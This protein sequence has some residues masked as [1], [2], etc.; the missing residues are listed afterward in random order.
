MSNSLRFVADETG[1]GQVLV[2]L[3]GKILARMPYQAAQQSA[4]ALKL[5]ASIAENNANPEKTI[6]DQSLLMR[7]GCPIGLTG[8]RKIIDESYK[9]A[10]HNKDLRRYMRAAEN[11]QSKEFFHLPMIKGGRHGMV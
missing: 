4:K 6:A 5:V 3:D 11:I 10:Q 8:D 2:V 7:A 1:T 9:E